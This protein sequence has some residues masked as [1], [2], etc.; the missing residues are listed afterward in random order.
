MHSYVHKCIYLLYKQRLRL[1][2]Q[3]GSTKLHKTLVCSHL[4]YHISSGLYTSWST[5]KPLR[6]S[7][8]KFTWIRS[9]RLIWY[10]CKELVHLRPNSYLYPTILQFCRI[11]HWLSFIFVGRHLNQRLEFWLRSWLQQFCNCIKIFQLIVKYFSYLNTWTFFL[12]RL[13]LFLIKML[14]VLFHRIDF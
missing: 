11:W 8:R 12:K 2:K 5:H 1:Q 4:E 3:P 13:F 7:G 6:K 9:D 10:L 14:M